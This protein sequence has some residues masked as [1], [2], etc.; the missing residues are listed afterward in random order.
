MT[1]DNIQVTIDA[2]VYYRVLVP[3]KAIYN[4]DNQRQAVRDLAFASLKAV[5]GN[6]T[7]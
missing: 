2:S 6:A 1:K 4:I 3:T 7:L 5:S